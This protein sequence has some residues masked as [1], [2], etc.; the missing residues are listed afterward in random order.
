MFLVH[1]LNLI[2][3]MIYERH[4][5]LEVNT[6]KFIEYICIT[7]ET[8]MYSI[9]NICQLSSCFVCQAVLHEDYPMPELYVVQTCH[10]Y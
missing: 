3:T 2:F 8:K 6:I 4:T 7:V 10:F 9:Y 5:E 1:L